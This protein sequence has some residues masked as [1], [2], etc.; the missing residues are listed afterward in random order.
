M[1]GKTLHQDA[2]VRFLQVTVTVECRWINA[3]Q[4]PQEQSGPSSSRKLSSYE[5]LYTIYRNLLLLHSLCEGPCHCEPR[6]L[7]YLSISEDHVTE[8]APPAVNLRHFD[9]LLHSG[10]LLQAALSST[11]WSLRS[12]PTQGSWA[13]CRLQ[14]SSGL[15]Q[16]TDG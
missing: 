14:D 3:L 7:L 10:F 5:V 9:L 1:A 6:Y 4:C 12:H 2:E 15:C 13:P 11:P 16:G 8:A